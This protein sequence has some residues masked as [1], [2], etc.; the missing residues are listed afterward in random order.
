MVRKSR[1]LLVLATLVVAFGFGLSS[2]AQADDAVSYI[3]EF[4]NGAQNGGWSASAT[5]GGDN[6]AVPEPGTI[7]LIGLGLTSLGILRRRRKH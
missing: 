6:V 3:K 4:D 1:F 7:A 5:R 2:P